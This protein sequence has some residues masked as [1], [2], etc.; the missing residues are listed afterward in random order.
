MSNKDTQNKKTSAYDF[1]INDMFL[2]R[3]VEK[4]DKEATKKFNNFV[5]RNNEF[6]DKKTLKLQARTEKVS[7]EINANCT[8]KPNGKVFEKAEIRNPQDYLNDQLKYFQTRDI[9]IKQ[10]QEDIKKTTDSKIQKVPEIS[11]KSKKLAQ[12]RLTSDSTSKE[13]HDRLFQEKLH[14]E[15][16]DIYVEKENKDKNSLTTGKNKTAKKYVHKYTPPEKKSKEEISSLVQK[17]F[18]DADVRKDNKNKTAKNKLK[19]K[20]VY[21]MYL[22]EDELTSNSSKLKILEKFV[23]GY[24]LTLNK[25][26][27]KKDSLL[28]NFDEFANLMYNLGFLKYDHN[29][30]S[31]IGG[32]H[33]LINEVLEESSKNEINN[34]SSVQEIKNNRNS[35][36]TVQT[37][38]KNLDSTVPNNNLTTRGGDLDKAEK[39]K[40]KQEKEFNLL[41]DSW[42]ILSTVNAVSNTSNT[43]DVNTG[44]I[45]NTHTDD[46]IDTNQLLVFCSGLLGLYK[47]EDTPTTTEGNVNSRPN[48]YVAN[49]EAKH[50][51][52]VTT[53]PT[54]PTEDM[55]TTNNLNSDGIPN[56]TESNLNNVEKTPATHPTREMTLSSPQK[57]KKRKCPNR[58]STPMEHH[59]WSTL[60]GTSFSLTTTNKNAKKIDFE[61]LA[62]ENKNLLKIVVPELDMARYH[63]LKNTVKQIKI[64]FRNMYD[65]RVEFLVLQKRKAKEEKA[66]MSETKDL[67][68]ETMN[69]PNH[70]LRQS[71]ENFRKRVYE[72]I[73]S[74]IYKK[75]EETSQSP[76]HYDNKVNRKLRLDEVYDILRKKKEK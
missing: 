69:Q 22:S 75:T 35:M 32:T 49:N 63:Y 52:V 27:N 30:S 56:T 58:F 55:T 13:V 50:D 46:R 12:K 10:Q 34:E 4:G 71:A 60:N 68:R 76:D 45:Q 29:I 31:S 17:L 42:K 21:K 67:L 18:K 7:N 64:L 66:R 62:K 9:N 25:L 43:E 70:R 61:K 1:L 54:Q 3:V 41:K 39:E 72:E 33:T 47:G 44:T 15:K 74:E 53:H 48:T 14:K 11:K 24:E 73:E 28:I 57:N 2:N 6:R 16:K 23:Q 8:G 38:H 36:M 65:N 37:H 19:L 20:E 40:K 26:F 5:V 51:L 59:N